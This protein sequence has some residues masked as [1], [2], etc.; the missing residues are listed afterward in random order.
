[1]FQKGD[2]IIYGNT[3]VC[4]V[5]DICT[6]DGISAA[7]NDKLYYRLTPVYGQGTIYIPVDTSIYMR[8]VISRE[9][10]LQLISDIP[11][12]QADTFC[13]RDQRILAEHYKE[14]IHSHEC[15]TLIQLIKT[16]YQK[17][18]T[19]TKQRKRPCQTDLQYMKKA[20][21]LL[22]GEISVALGIPLEKVPDYISQTISESNASPL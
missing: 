17:T 10:A 4:Q 21:E 20:E 1:M 15:E 7:S 22:H 8:P 5:E 19:V 3:G 18:Q 2:Y 13:S 16:L 9:Q 14:K 12:I 6:P 11:A